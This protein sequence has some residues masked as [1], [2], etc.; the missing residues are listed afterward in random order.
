MPEIVRILVVEDNSDQRELYRDAAAEKQTGDLQIE[1][2]ERPSADEAKKELLSKDFDGAIVDINL[3]PGDPGEA[4]GNE[5]LLEITE[6]H[7]FP[8]LVVSGN[9]QNLD[10]RITSSGFLKTFERDSPNEEIFDYLLKVHCTGITRILGGR[11][12]IERYLGEIFWRHL[13]SDFENWDAGKRDSERT[14]LRYTVGHL[15]EYLDRPDGDGNEY[16][17]EAEFYIIP[18][19]TEHISTGDI[20]ERD[21]NCYIVLSPPCDVA[22]RGED[23]GKPDIN[24]ESIVLAPLVLVD[25]ASFIQNGLIKDGGDRDNGRGRERLL[26][27][28]IKGKQEKYVFLPGYRSIG[29]AIADLQN[30]CT[31]ALDEFLGANRLATVSGAFLKDIQSKFAAYYGRQGQPDLDKRELLGKY[32][33]KL[34]PQ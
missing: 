17:H 30:L 28:L 16:Y 1:L 19:I 32:K 12:L 24:A 31:W 14:L 13:A 15:A 2:V 7:R 9:L 3:S 18:P 25:R 33:A 11:G 27:D 22:V 4:S 10:N 21:G 5:V 34:A 26:E 29:P 23:D 20:V 8:V 6:K